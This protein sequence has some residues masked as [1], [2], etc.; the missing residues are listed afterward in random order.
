VAGR[1]IIRGTPVRRPRWSG[2]L[3]LAAAT[4]ALITYVNALDNPFVYDDHDTVL[5]NRSL[6]D[7]TNLRFILVYTPFRPLVNA[8]YAFDRWLWNYRPAGY[9]LTNLALHALAVVLL[10]AWI[11]RALTDASASDDSRLPAFAG[12]ALFAVHPL[13]SEAVAYVSG[14]SEVLC[15][16]WFIGALL[17]AR[18]AILSNSRVKAVLAAGCGALALASKE[19]AVVLPIVFLAYDWLLR[20]GGNE[21]RRRRLFRIMVPLCVLFAVAAV[22]R[23]LTLPHRATGLSTAILNALTQAI[24]IWRYLGL[25][26]WPWG[27]SVM[28]SVHQVTTLADPLAWTATMGIGLVIVAAFGI[29]RSHPVVALGMVWFLVVLAPSSSFVPLRE[30]MAE[31]R[32]YLA[33]AGF[34]MGLAAI[35]RAWWA[36]NRARLWLARTACAAVVIVLCLLAVLR[37]QVWSDPVTLW[38]EATLHAEGMWEPH[39]ALADSLREGGQCAAAVPEYQKVVELRPSH[40]D[41]HTNLGICLAQTGQ[42]GEAEREF[43]LALAIDPTFARGYTN[44]GALSLLTGDP[45]RAREFYLQAIVQ[46]PDNVLAR[47]QLASLY[48]KTFHDYHAAARMCGEARLLAPATPGIVECVERNQRL[49]AGEGR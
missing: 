32:V 46:D 7:L 2:W 49:A 48:E 25:L 27:Q 21:F 12:A 19:T 5:S 18:D 35:L 45:V 39:Y 6:V 37:N 26:V 31:H 36:P 3:P 15:A 40:R 24:V 8:S 9:H 22:Y 30:G 10:Y 17:L 29:R 33:S 28:H 1:R 42:P 44:L 43:R 4:L 13:Q 14:R 23:L 38:T 20:P 47:L 16:V 41:A 34:F 11:R